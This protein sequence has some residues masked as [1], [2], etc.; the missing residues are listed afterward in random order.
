MRCNL[1][2]L[3]VPLMLLF[4][5]QIGWAQNGRDRAV[6][7]L[8]K[9]KKAELLVV[10]DDGDEAYNEAIKEAIS[11]YWTFTP[12][13][14]IPASGFERLCIGGRL[15]HACAQQFQKDYQASGQ[16]RPYPEQSS[17]NIC[18]WQR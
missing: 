11:K 14:F 7:D 2:F 10:L 3:I 18:L 8:K 4:G 6:E 13:L 9:L 16:N 12:Y 1:D 17:G 15:R 5:L